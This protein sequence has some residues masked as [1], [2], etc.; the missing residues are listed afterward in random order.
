MLV[1]VR[2]RGAER[3]IFARFGKESHPGHS[4]EKSRSASIAG[5]DVVNTLH[6]KVSMLVEESNPAEM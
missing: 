4:V 5:V 3:E 2:R 6:I 1:D